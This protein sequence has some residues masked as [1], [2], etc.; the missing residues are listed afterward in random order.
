MVNKNIKLIIADVDGTLIEPSTSKAPFPSKSLVETVKQLQNRGIVFSLATARSLSHTINLTEGLQLTGPVIFDN[1]ARIYDCKKNKYLKE[2]YIA[3]NKIKESVGIIKEISP[4]EKLIIVDDNLRLSQISQIK[5]WQVTKI[6]VLGITPELAEKLYHRL[7][8]LF[9]I[10]VTKSISGRGEKSES[11]HITNN[12]ATKAS[13][14][15]FISR[16]L[17]IKKNEI[18]GIG[19]SYN[20]L[21]MLLACGYKVAMGNSIPQ[22]LK[23]ADYIAPNYLNNGV[24]ETLKRIVLGVL[25]DG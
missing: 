4:K 6:I 2:L 19:D 22:V 8:Q 11:I 16:L 23:I 21:E 17:K 9:G 18:M 1:G 13:G 24:E 10:T 25:Q 14:V 7:S 5:K 20:D 15:E 3:K 12:K